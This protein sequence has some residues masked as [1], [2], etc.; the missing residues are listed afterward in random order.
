MHSIVTILITPPLPLI[1]VALAGLLT[2][3]RRYDRGWWL[4]AISL[5]ILY[6]LATPLVSQTLLSSLQTYPP[7]DPETVRTAPADAIVILSAEAKVAPEFG[8]L[9]VG[10]LTLQRLHYGVHLHSQVMRPILVTGGIWMSS[11]ARLGDLMAKTL[12]TE[13]AIPDVW[14]E[15]QAED[16]WENAV[17][18]TNILNKKGIHR[19]YLVTHAWHMQRAVRAFTRQGID[20]VPAPTAFIEL[21]TVT[22]DDLMPSANGFITSYYFFHEAIGLLAYRMLK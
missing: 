18:S 7:L 6:A 5:F 4:A 15:A 22:I 10:P 3:R 2:L 17:Y 12:A 11:P 21:G 19:I 20:V 8:G 13:F 9:T 14:V 1:I 16:T